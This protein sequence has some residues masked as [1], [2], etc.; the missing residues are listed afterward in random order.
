[1]KEKIASF[2]CGVCLSSSAIDLFEATQ[3]TS[4]FTVY[5]AATTVAL[6]LLLITIDVYQEIKR[7]KK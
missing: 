5:T 1:M 4:K 3:K 6:C 7:R 2:L